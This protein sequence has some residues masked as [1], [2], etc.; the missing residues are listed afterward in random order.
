M[1][2]KAFKN[3][4]LQ[5]KSTGRKSRLSKIAKVDESDIDRVEGMLPYL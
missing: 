4:L 1:R 3:H 5:H 2:R